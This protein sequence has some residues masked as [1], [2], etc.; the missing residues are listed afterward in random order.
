MNAEGNKQ[1]QSV[2]DNDD[3]FL[4]KE[5]QDA[6]EEW[7]ILCEFFPSIDFETTRS[8][9]ARYSNLNGVDAL[10]AE[11]EHNKADY[12]KQKSSFIKENNPGISEKSKKLTEARNRHSLFSRLWKI[13]IF[14]TVACLMLINFVGYGVVRGALNYLTLFAFVSIPVF[15]IKNSLTSSKERTAFGEYCFLSNDL[16]AKVK[17]LSDPYLAR[18]SDLYNQVDDIYLRSLDPT[19]RET[20]MMRR[21]QER[22]HQETLQAQKEHNARLAEDQR[23]ALEAQQETARTTQ[24]LLDIEEKR[25]YD[26]K[27]KYL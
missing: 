8:Y 2:S 13:A 6:H 20:V 22:H 25:E 19:H 1:Y 11:I 27:K 21:D 24:R 12:L 16:E 4:K 18:N 15:L 23:R 17:A 14:L 3:S 10:I 9:A 7:S 5:S 26:R